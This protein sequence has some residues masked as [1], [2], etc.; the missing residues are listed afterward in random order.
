MLKITTL[1]A[2]SGLEKFSSTLWDNSK[3]AIAVLFKVPAK[4]S[5][6]LNDESGR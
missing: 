3:I 4:I 1:L 6:K 2:L 5:A